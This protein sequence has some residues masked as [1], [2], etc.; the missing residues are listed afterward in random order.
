MH[1]TIRPLTIEHWPAFEDLFGAA[2]ASN[3]CWCMYWRMGPAYRERPRDRNRR[4]LRATVRR[5]PSPGLLAFDGDKAV[6]WCQLTPRASLPH[7]DREIG[8]AHV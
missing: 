7:L 2:G 8:R 5:G 3:G 4:A 6:G 1:L